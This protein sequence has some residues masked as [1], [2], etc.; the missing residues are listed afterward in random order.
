MTD[1][2]TPGGHRY[3]GEEAEQIMIE[4]KDL[5]NLWN[6]FV[7][8][9]TSGR[10]PV[11][12]HPPPAFMGLYAALMEANSPLDELLENHLSS[13]PEVLE[14]VE[15]AML[16]IVAFGDAMYRFGQWCVQ[17]GMLH[18]NAVPCKCGAVNDDELRDLTAPVVD[19]SD[20]SLRNFVE[21]KSA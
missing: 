1:E 8:L 5:Q 13:T 17:Q 15:D 7:E 9:Q 14:A 12:I 19:L 4:M 16:K 21:G 20:E 3:E 10:I 18:A 2:P 11:G 6:H